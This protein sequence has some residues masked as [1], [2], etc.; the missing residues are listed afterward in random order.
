[1]CRDNVPT[2][3]LG[4]WEVGAKLFDGTIAAGPVPTLFSEDI[5][6]S[7]E[8]LASSPQKAHQDL[9]RALKAFLMPESVELKEA[10]ALVKK[11]R[12]IV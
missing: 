9:Q 7:K 1:L 10:L 2:I 5:P 4:F 8:A 3:N 6:A 12:Y 11:S